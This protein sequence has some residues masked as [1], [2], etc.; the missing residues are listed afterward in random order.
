METNLD[1]VS[2]TATKIKLDKNFLIGAA[3]G[4]TVIAGVLVT[5]KVIE[6]VK[7]LREAETVEETTKTA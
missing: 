6:R 3:A 2:T 1:L 5:R 4:A 7:A